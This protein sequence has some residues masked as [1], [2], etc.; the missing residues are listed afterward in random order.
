ML[1]RALV[2]RELLRGGWSYLGSQ[3]TSVEATTLAVMALRTELPEAAR[4][5]LDQVARLQRRDGAWPAFGGDS[6]SSWTTALVLCALNGI[7]EFPKA[8]EKAF[9]WLVSER[10]REGH[11]FWRWKFKTA[12]RKVRFDPDKY[13]WPWASGSAS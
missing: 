4:S 2:T 11:W 9:Q 13:G 1:G 10:G 8:R 12:D 7:D 3:Q 6:D 5:G